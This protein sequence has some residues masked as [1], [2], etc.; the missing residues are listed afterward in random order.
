MSMAAILRIALS[1]VSSNSARYLS[2]IKRFG[3]SDPRMSASVLHSPSG[4]VFVSG[5]TASDVEGIA[6]QTEKVLAKVDEKLAQAG[7]D[8]SKL[9]QAQIWLKD[10]K[11]FKEMNA[12][13]IAWVDPD[14]KPARATTQAEMANP[15]ILVEV[16][17]VAASGE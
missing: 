8:K 4:L 15:R 14:N 3:T 9:L 13:W 11:D 12:A 7:T 17:V 16:M 1:R 2:G 6:A 10:I 5:Q